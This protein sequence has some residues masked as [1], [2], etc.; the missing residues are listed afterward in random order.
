MRNAPHLTQPL[1]TPRAGDGENWAAGPK[2][3]IELAKGS[4]ARRFSVPRMAMQPP[5]LSHASALLTTAAWSKRWNAS[6]MAIRSTEPGAMAASSALPTTQAM[7]VI[8]R[9]AA[10][11]PPTLTI[12]GSRSTAHTRSKAPARSKATRPGPHV[13]SR[14]TGAGGGRTTCPTRSARRAAGY[15]GLYRR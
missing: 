12:S 6:P 11:S 5:G 15:G 8:P 14:R 4:P 3:N 7:F 2:V 10:F 13:R 9:S 1:A